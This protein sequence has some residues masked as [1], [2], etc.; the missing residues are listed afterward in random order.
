MNPVCVACGVEMS[1]KKT[2]FNV[3]PESSPT[4]VRSGDMFQCEEC[5][6][7]VAVG[8]GEPY[9]SKADVLLKE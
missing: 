3:A 4:W 1:C 7:Q 6:I 5:N 2:G 8:F 9:N